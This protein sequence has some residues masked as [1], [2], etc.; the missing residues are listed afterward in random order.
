M[1]IRALS[2]EMGPVAVNP[3]LSTSAIEQSLEDVANGSFN[4]ANFFNNA[5][6]LGGVDLGTIVEI[7]STLTGAE[8]PKLLSRELPD[9]IVSSFDW[10]TEVSQSDPLNLL[11]PRADGNQTTTRLVMSG[12]VTT[13]VADPQGSHYEA[14]AS[15]DNFKVNL[16]GFVIIWFKMLRF[17]AAKGQKPDVAVD[18]KEGNQA[19]QFGGPLE[20]VN[21]LRELVPSNGFSDPPASPRPAKRG[22]SR[23]IDL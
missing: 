10:D 16:F 13:P 8:V 12:T 11:I 6:I 19:V 23:P 21:Q 20:F 18:L 17:T 5:N 9:K 1:E 4:P 15:L 7:A 22:D 14:T 3:A 2:K